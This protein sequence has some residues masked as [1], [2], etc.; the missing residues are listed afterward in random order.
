MGLEVR[1]GNPQDLP[2]Y[3]L[4]RIAFLHPEPPDFDELKELVRQ[5]LRMMCQKT[6]GQESY[7]KSGDI[8][9]EGNYERVRM[10]LL[11]NGIR[12]ARS[13]VLDNIDLTG[14]MPPPLI[15]D[16]AKMKDRD[17][18]EATIRETFYGREVD[19]D[20]LRRLVDKLE[21]R[22][23]EY[24]KRLIILETVMIVLSGRLEQVNGFG[25]SG[26]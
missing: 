2:E 8:K 5:L 17:R 26:R 25:S 7:A 4:M 12:L 1:E 14:P 20:T 19:A 24:T 13:G 16:K 15:V 3:F 23:D 22:E 21:E 11:N 10:G 18:N 9:T 6:A